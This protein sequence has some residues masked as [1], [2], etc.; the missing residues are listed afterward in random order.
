MTVPTVTVPISG[1]VRVRRRRRA[2]QLLVAVAL[3]GGLA[4][5]P[6]AS[7][8][9][10][11]YLVASDPAAGSTVRTAPGSVSLTF[12]A[13][14]LD[15]GRGSTALQVT[16]PGGASRH[17]ETG[18]AKVDGRTVTA[19]VALGGPGDYIETWRVVSAD[20]HPVSA[21]IRFRYAPSAGR[22]SSAGSPTGPDCGVSAAASGAVSRGPGW[23]VI[24]LVVAG[25]LVVLAALAG[26]VLLVLRATRVPVGVGAPAAG[27]AGT[28][29]DPAAVDDES[30]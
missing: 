18:C 16:G 15:Y 6:A 1:A 20:G 24:A 19:R 7:A 22:H 8:S 21:S 2:A 12:D 23:F 28:G 30:R 26:V 5:L 14:V 13:V 27:P 11:D 9:A 29:P 25:G 3:G 10:H 4:L 17:F